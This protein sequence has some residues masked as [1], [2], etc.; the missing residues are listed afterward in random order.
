LEK[1]SYRKGK[2][3]EQELHFRKQSFALSF[4]PH[5]PSLFSAYFQLILS[6][7][8]FYEREIENSPKVTHWPSNDL[9][10]LTHKLLTSG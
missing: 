3:I 4:T 6:L 5:F 7:W 9:F 8:V 2:I 10:F 1:E